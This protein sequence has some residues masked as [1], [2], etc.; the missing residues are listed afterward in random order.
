M[1]PASDAWPPKSTLTELTAI[2]LTGANDKVL[3]EQECLLRLVDQIIMEATRLRA[4]TIRLISRVGRSG[5]IT[6]EVDK[7]RRCHE[8][9]PSPLIP[10]LAYWFEHLSALASVEEA[11]DINGT[12]IL[13]LR[14]LKVPIDVEIIASSE[15][16]T[17]RVGIDWKNPV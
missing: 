4:T 2:G 10:K 7:M 1:E 17:V 15:G 13:V 5:E 3:L 8:S 9:L 16:E 11:T 12:H 14:D 6:F